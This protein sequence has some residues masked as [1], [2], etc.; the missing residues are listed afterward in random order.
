MRCGGGGSESVGDPKQA[1]HA[2][3][4]RGWQE[5]HIVLGI[6]IG[7]HRQ[8]L[9]DDIE[10]AFIR[11]KVEWGPAILR[12]WSGGKAACG[13]KKGWWQER[14]MSWG[15]LHVVQRPSSGRQSVTGGGRSKA[16]SQNGAGGLETK[17]VC[18][19]A[20]GAWGEVY[21]VCV[22]VQLA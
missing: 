22:H 14:S 15:R 8:K 21:G 19:G 11:R 5:H 7:A 2:A 18:F 10:P 3:R 6:N 13:V 16:P 12:R 17:I 9:V 4:G 1:R 20:S